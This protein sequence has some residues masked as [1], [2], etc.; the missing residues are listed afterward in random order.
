MSNIKEFQ[1]AMAGSEASSLGGGVTVAQAFDLYALFAKAAADGMAS[2]TTADTPTGFHNPFDFSLFVVG[3][4]L[5]VTATG[6]TGDNANNAVITIKTNDGAGGA[7]AIAL[8][9]TTD[10]ATGNFAINQ[11]KA[12]TSVTAAGQELVA[13]GVLWFN[14]A[15]NGTG[16]VVPPTN[17]VIRLRRGEFQGT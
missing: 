8:T 16:V 14:I 7:T 2:T 9:I 3:G 11:P 12:F 15:K 13:G 17:F 4:R 1:K 6:I 5:A 10:V